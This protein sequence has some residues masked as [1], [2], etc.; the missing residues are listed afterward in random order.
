MTL[1]RGEPE[2][3]VLRRMLF[4]TCRNDR[5]SGGGDCKTSQQNLYS[6]VY[7]LRYLGLS[8]AVVG[9]TCMSRLRSGWLLGRWSLGQK[10]GRHVGAICWLTDD[11]HAAP[12]TDEFFTAA[13]VSVPA[14]GS[15]TIPPW[16]LFP[17]G[18][19][20]NLAAGKAVHKRGA[21]LKGKNTQ[22]AAASRQSETTPNLVHDTDGVTAVECGK[23]DGGCELAPVLS[24]EPDHVRG[25]D[26][27]H[28][29]EHSLSEASAKK[30]MSVVG[31]SPNDS[32]EAEAVSAPK[33][34][35]RA[36]CFDDDD[37][38]QMLDEGDMSPLHQQFAHDAPPDES[39]LP[40]NDKPV[41]N[42]TTSDTAQPKSVSA[43]MPTRRSA[44]FDDPEDDW[45]VSGQEGMSPLH[46]PCADDAPPDESDLPLLPESSGQS[47]AVE[48]RSRK[49]SERLALRMKE[50]TEAALQFQPLVVDEEKCRA[51]QWNRGR[52]RLQCCRLPLPGT[53]LCKMHKTAA[54]GEVR[55]PIPMKKLQLFRQEFLKPEKDSKQW[56]ARSLMWGVAANIAPDITSL[57]GLTPEQYEV[58]L[59]KVS[60]YVRKNNLTGKLKQGVGVRGIEDQD[61]DDKFGCARERYNGEGGGKVFKWYSRAVFINYLSRMQTTPAECNEKECMLALAAV[62]NELKKYPMIMDGLTAYAGPQCFPHLNKDGG[63]YR[64]HAN[65]VVHKED[66]E[67]KG[68]ECVATGVFD[69]E[70]WRQ[71]D[72]CSRWRLLDRRCLP[73]TSE[74]V[75]MAVRDTDLDWESWLE[76]AGARY[77]AAGL[78][79]THDVCDE[80][81]AAG[82]TSVDAPRKRLCVKTPSD[83]AVP[84]V[85]QGAAVDASTRRR[86]LSIKSRSDPQDPTRGIVDGASAV[87]ATAESGEQCLPEGSDSDCRSPSEWEKGSESDNAV[88]VGASVRPGLD[89]ALAGLRGAGPMSSEDV[90]RQKGLATKEDMSA[91]RLSKSTRTSVH[92]VGD[93]GTIQEVQTSK[94]CLALCDFLE[95]YSGRTTRVIV[96]HA[97]AKRAW[98]ACREGRRSSCGSW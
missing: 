29:H 74:N 76:C 20:K 19:P 80:D 34:V 21:H 26:G 39:D 97:D 73:A 1:M 57:S 72:T 63:E 6:V 77:D 27:L 23:D 31:P 46:A 43:P 85:L 94:M 65:D 75:Y 53:R 50:E 25:R 13:E 3:N 90:R 14:A 48:P 70:C 61:R 28:A 78:S 58:C 15:K 60:D 89:N 67:M 16:E 32:G 92:G 83:V 42:G 91:T 38:W 7:A 40:V 49:H 54:H 45:Q 18:A 59:R 10:D 62:S 47:K 44:C 88:G 95:P 87:R 41:A 69:A 96:S 71:C 52:G 93:I 51:L 82:P 66:V 33:P 2:E 37:D 17:V 56:Y 30:D 64:L 36:P 5:S 84:S 86:R 4:A 12:L 24:S 79:S 98:K 11:A 9:A 35:R 55:G 81:V 68:V 22:R 8:V